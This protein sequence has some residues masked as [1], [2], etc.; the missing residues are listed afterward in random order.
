MLTIL[1]MSKYQFLLPAYKGRYL[2]EM[3]NSL[4]AQTYT[5]FDVLISD[6]NSPEDIK[7]IC[8]VYLKDARFHYRRNEKNLGNY[9][10][11]SH[12]NYLIE[13]CNTDYVIIASDDDIYENKFLEKVNELIDKYPKTDLIRTRVRKI[14]ENREPYDEDCLFPETEDA[15]H[16]LHSSF[17]NNRIH[18]IGNYIFKTE[19]LKKEGGFV[20]FPLA[21]F[22]DDATVFTCGKKGIVNTKDILFN[23]RIS[24][25][26]ISNQRNYNPIIAKKKIEATCK[27]YEWMNNFIK[28]LSFSDSLLCKT[29]YNRMYEGFNSRVKWQ[30]FSY[31][32]QI[33]FKSFV[34]V[35]KWMKKKHLLSFKGT[36]QSTLFWIKHKYIIS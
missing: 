25:I 14:N 23:F 2:D 35:T 28:D 7:S 29:L 11:T 26:N 10:L 32:C 1:I 30:I 20:D 6:D 15:L 27:F 21:W 24:P 22:S 31:Y 4:Q 36:I 3:L 18:C 34:L 9:S 17:C 33:D 16:F 13:R 19:T 5:D 8:S 12:W